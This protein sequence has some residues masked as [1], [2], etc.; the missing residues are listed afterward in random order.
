MAKDI[1]IESVSGLIKKI[2]ADGSG[3]CILTIGAPGVGKSY[4]TNKYLP[5][6]KQIDYDAE[7]EEISRSFGT[8]YDAKHKSKGMHSAFK[9][10]AEL[11]KSKGSFIYQGTSANTKSTENK[12]IR[13]KEA[14]VMTMLLYI[15]V[16][17]EQALK[18][19]RD[20]IEAGG[21]GV[22]AEKEYKIERNW[23]DAKFTFDSLKNNE[24]VD[25][26]C[27]YSNIRNDNNLIEYV[28][29]VIEN[30][31]VNGAF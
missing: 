30:C 2:E 8:A 10:V 6:V 23:N 25:F 28:K 16:P 4:V 20:R 3:I 12:L 5:G 31:F 26:V 17:L 22:P 19:N 1:K 18:Q 11:L 14:G 13:A 21:R 27:H 9:K 7:V 29:E 15:D 24:N